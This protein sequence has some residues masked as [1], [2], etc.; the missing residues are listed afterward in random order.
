MSV[1]YPDT[2]EFEQFLQ[3]CR[4][5]FVV[6]T[7]LRGL[8][9]VLTVLLAVTLCSTL[10]DFLSPLSGSVRLVLLIVSAAVVGVVSW[11]VIVW[12]LT[13]GISDAELGAAAD[14]ACPEFKEAVATVVSVESP[15]A[16]R[17]EAGSRRMRA[18]VWQQICDRLP[19]ES[20]LAIMDRRTTVLRCSAAAA[21]LALA[22]IPLLAWQSGS[23]LLLQRF[24][25]PLTSRPTATNLYFSIESPGDIAARGSDVV[26]RAVPNWRDGREHEPPREARVVLSAESGRTDVLVMNYDPAVGCLTG[27]LR[28]ISD[29]V[30]WRVESGRTATA[31]RF[32]RVVDSPRQTA[33]SLTATPPE[34][35]RLAPQ[36]FPDATGRMEVFAG[37]R[38]EVQLEFNKPV[39]MAS[40]Q[41]AEPPEGQP[42]LSTEDREPDA[43]AGRPAG[44]SAISLSLAEDRLSAS[45]NWA[46]DRGGV[47]RLHLTD[48]DG[49]TNPDD[50]T[51][52]LTLI[53][54]QPPEL[55]VRGIRSGDA[56]RPDD[57]IPLNCTVV[58]DLGV[59][60]LEVHLQLP[61][62]ETEVLPAPGDQR[63]E[64]ER[65]HGFRI[66]LAERKL[67]DG[68]RLS[69]RVRATDLRHPEPQEIWSDEIRL[70]IDREA[71]ANGAQALS[72]ESR[73]LIEQLE[74][75]RSQL[76]EDVRA[77][78]QLRRTP[79]DD[80]ATQTTASPEQLSERQQM[81]G[82][83]LE[84]LAQQAERHPLMKTP[85]G[86]LGELGQ[87][88]RSETAEP[89]Q[90]A[91]EQE[92]EESLESLRQAEEQMVDARSEL[93]Q[94]ID[95]VRRAGELEQDLAELNRLALEAEQ[96]ADSAAE[97]RQRQQMEEDELP[98][99]VSP[100]EHQQQLQDD[101]ER[102][103]QTRQQLSDDLTRLLKEQRELQAAAQR[104]LLQRQSDVAG[105][106]DALAERQENLATLMQ[107]ENEADPGRTT[108]AQQQIAQETKPLEEELTEIGRQIQLPGVGLADQSS[109]V[110][111]A[112]QSAASATEQA[113]AAEQAA[114]E[115]N[116]EEAAESGRQAASALERVS[117]LGEQAAQ[118]SRSQPSI[119]P[120]GQSVTQALQNLTAAGQPAPEPTGSDDSAGRDEADAGDEPSSGDTDGQT[121]PAG[122]NGA[123]SS[124]TSDGPDSAADSG[125]ESSD[126]DGDPTPAGESDLQ[127]AS[128]ADGRDQQLAE[129]AAALSAAA[130]ASLPESP[131]SPMSQMPLPG[132]MAGSAPTGVET[133][134]H[135]N[136][137]D[138]SSAMGSQRDWTRLND[139]L[140]QDILSESQEGADGRYELMIRAYFRELARSSLTAE[141]EAE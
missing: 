116:A 64:P 28:T 1:R 19:Q 47:L 46:A 23:F 137:N 101:S 111:A 26:F 81:L 17:N 126:A 91:G 106:A 58:D 138:L 59:G 103:E 100:Q 18:R 33:G 9:G 109:A 77:V 85:A 20:S 24:L 108:A 6:H 93:S 68:D 132:Q 89:L 118:D 43:E 128:P 78:R 62:G 30:V 35:T 136:S 121:Q 22:I 120:A 102:V 3:R 15:Q 104:A 49:L 107:Y 54:D 130:W 139:E 4:R 87:S 32:L 99:D 90:Q 39:T 129:A 72:E 115:G 114:R 75:A 141:T 74:S 50:P 57:I 117:Q 131:G 83:Q 7:A 69:L 123:P 76:A 25:I 79:R 133:R 13:S 31:D 12:P 34:Y 56:V 127:G 98:S 10:L 37:S 48:D 45:A 105:Q 5:R 97:L 66:D 119:V 14:L 94:I 122:E 73:A 88:L 11:K 95:Q 65:A 44:S 70:T 29:S 38:L 134:G 61:N 16:G 53:H 21:V 125:A 36:V 92:P 51:R 80:W 86:E 52:Q 2:S 135:I 113:A 82:R 140:R 27:T 71:A 63:G 40:L 60:D 8:A 110:E 124:E 112:R 84:G 41:W 42:M 67:Q 96:L 55:S